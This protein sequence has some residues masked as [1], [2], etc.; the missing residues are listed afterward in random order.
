MCGSVLIPKKYNPLL[1]LV[2]SKGMW[3]LP[4]IRVQMAL[5]NQ[6]KK[7]SSAEIMFMFGTER[8]VERAKVIVLKIRKGESDDQKECDC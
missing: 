5:Q 8:T 3:P 2:W 1:N 4:F 7:I 6:F